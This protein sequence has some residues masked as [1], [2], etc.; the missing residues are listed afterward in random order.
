MPIEEG[1]VHQREASLRPD[2]DEVRQRRQ[3]AQHLDGVV[4]GQRDRAEGLAAA[5]ARVEGGHRVDHGPAEAGQKAQASGEVGDR[6][7]D[8]VGVLAGLPGDHGLD[9]EL[10][11]RLDQREHGEGEALRHQEFGRLGAPRDDERGADHRRERPERRRTPSRS[12]AC[13]D[14]APNAPSRA[15]ISSRAVI[16]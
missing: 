8:H 9:R 1:G 13:A 7:V 14:D 5:A 16:A 10:R 4:V 3:E 12:A 6:E 11:H 15:A 2:D